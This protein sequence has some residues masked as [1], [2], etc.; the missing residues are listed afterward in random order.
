MYFGVNGPIS[1]L[2]GGVNGIASVIPGQRIKGLSGSQADSYQLGALVPVQLFNL[3]AAGAGLVAGTVEATFVLPTR[4]KIPKVNVSFSA[5]DTL[6]G[7]DLFNIVQGIAAYTA[8]VVA[9]ND[10]SSGSGICTDPAV[11]GDALF[12]IDVPFTVANFPGATTAGGS[13]GLGLIPTNPDAVYPCGAVLT[14]RLRTTASTGSLTQLSVTAV[15]IPQPLEP[16]F[17]SQ[18]VSPAPSVPIGGLDF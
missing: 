7:T 8:G 16:T 13:S 11:N 1:V 9:S 4:C 10:N 2:A 14:L 6:A 3:A 15:L 17:P 5:I 18:V 12:N